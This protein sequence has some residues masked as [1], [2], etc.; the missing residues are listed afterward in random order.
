MRI[1]LAAL[2]LFLIVAGCAG[3]GGSTSSAT[4][5]LQPTKGNQVGGTLTFTQKGDKVLVAAN[6]NGL[7]PGAH[8]IH[9]YEKGD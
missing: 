2:F 3:M 5:S 7:T 8:G 4:A 6:V 9:V 1:S